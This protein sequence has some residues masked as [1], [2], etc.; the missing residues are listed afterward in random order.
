MNSVGE[1]GVCTFT[2]FIYRIRVVVVVVVVVVVPRPKHCK[3]RLGIKRFL[4]DSSAL[5]L[6]DEVTNRFSKPSNLALLPEAPRALRVCVAIGSL[7][8]DAFRLLWEAL[9]VVALNSIGEGGVCTFTTFTYR[10]R[11]VVS[12]ML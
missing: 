1:G 4:Q 6:L 5:R 12:P 3:N 2:T 11:V 10:I 9:S 7:L 8:W